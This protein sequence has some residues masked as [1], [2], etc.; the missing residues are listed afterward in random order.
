MSNGNNKSSNQSSEDET[1]TPAEVVGPSGDGPVRCE[2]TGEAAFSGDV[3][4]PETKELPS[5]VA[6][7]F[8]KSQS[9]N[10]LS[11]PEKEV[12][13]VTESPPSSAEEEH[14]PNVPAQCISSNEASPSTSSSG[15]TS[16]KLTTPKKDK[17][18]KP[19]SS[20]DSSRAPKTTPKPN[21]SKPLRNPVDREASPNPHQKHRQA[22]SSKSTRK[23]TTSQ[24]DGK[25]R[26]GTESSS[27][28]S[29]D[30]V[31]LTCPPATTSTSKL[32]DSTKNQTVLLE[33]S[34]ET[35]ISE[36]D[37]AYIQTPASP[38]VEKTT[39][40]I[41]TPPLKK[42]IDAGSGDEQFD[43]D[44]E[45]AEE[46]DYAGYSSGS[47]APAP[48]LRRRRHDS[49]ASEDDH[50]EEEE[51]VYISDDEVDEE[52]GVPSDD[53]EHKEMEQV[54][55][56]AEKGKQ[57]EPK[58]PAQLE[59]EKRKDPAYVPRADTY[60]LHDM[61]THD[62]GE[63]NGSED[64]EGDEA[65]DDGGESAP[66]AT[67]IIDPATALQ[68]RRRPGMFA[69]RWGHDRY[70]ETEQIPRSS[71][72]LVRRYGYDI[73]K[74]GLDKAPEEVEQAVAA[75]RGDSLVRGGPCRRGGGRGSGFTRSGQ[76]GRASYHASAAR[77][78][79][80]DNNNNNR[81]N[82]EDLRQFLQQKRRDAVSNHAD[83]IRTG[84]PSRGV[85][86]RIRSQAIN[87]NQDDDDDNTEDLRHVI[88]RSRRGGYGRGG[89]N[90]VD[91]V[92]SGGEKDASK[93]QNNNNSSTEDL[94][95]ILQQSRRRPVGA[96]EEEE[97]G[98][99][100][101]RNQHL[102]RNNTRRDDQA[103]PPSRGRG[104]SLRHANND[105]GPRPI[106]RRGGVGGGRVGDREGPVEDK[107]RGSER[108]RGGDERRVLRGGYSSR[109]QAPLERF[110]PRSMDNQA[111]R[112]PQH[113]TTA[114]H[115]G[116][117]RYSTNRQPPQQHQTSPQSNVVLP[118]TQ[119]TEQQPQHHLQP[120]R[121]PF[122][123]ASMQRCMV[124]PVEREMVP[125][126]DTL[127]YYRSLD[128]SY[129]AAVLQQNAA[130]YAGTSMLLLVFCII[131][132]SI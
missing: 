41:E 20:I 27:S 119:T 1:K 78:G 57:D 76:R 129:V 126:A 94:R 49:I 55:E 107:L 61:R 82:V 110:P 18:L 25:K 81:E 92:R 116:A 32:P 97:A 60:Y 83:D 12:S 93:L 66:P 124:E 106:V 131:I 72:E 80:D 43:S 86:G 75:P 3:S 121:E 28:K 4:S 64:T 40:P 74:H 13:A 42:I 7:E 71:Q 15:P 51:D 52:A 91:D 87:N 95:H 130:M 47:D 16:I 102:R 69:E 6:V 34:V 112:L 132:F 118:Q 31:D 39:E 14:S 29:P 62:A 33:D 67:P 73:R 22:S 36:G 89:S 45:D 88:Q 48:R 100:F 24:K 63:A 77:R 46:E 2:E 101:A 65:I 21:F 35:T 79:D 123:H 23:K 125:D 44:E 105:S 54:A 59:A 26:S 84:I 114:A 58:T 122:Y 99:V 111:P 85:E 37:S 56:K 9:P 128:P 10:D 117:K 115:V 53:E 30:P 8:S 50:D 108:P 120:P 11:F 38:S 5:G 127:K 96:H 104:G 19:E 113:T 70:N 90:Y 98:G 109:R 103:F 17:T 68:A